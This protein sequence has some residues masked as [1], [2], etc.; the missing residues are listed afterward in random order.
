MSSCPDLS[1][2][3]KKRLKNDA[4]VA[5]KWFEAAPDVLL[6]HPAELNPRFR[7]LSPARLG[8]SRKRIANVR[9]SVR[10]VLR[11]VDTGSGWSLAKELS[12]DWR[13]LEAK[14]PD[15]YRRA[16][17]RCLVQF[18]SACGVPPDE[19]D[20]AQSAR[21]LD[22]LENSRLRGRPKVTHKNAVRV[23][24]QLA[25]MVEGW[26]RQK[27]TLPRYGDTYVLPWG[28]FPRSLVADVERFLDRGST[29]DPFDL[30]RPYRAWRPQTVATYRKLLRRFASA[31]VHAGVEAERIKTLADLCSIEKVTLGLRWC[32]DRKP[33]DSGFVAASNMAR[34]LAQIARN[35]NGKSHLTAVEQQKYENTAKEI[36]ELAHRLRQRAPEAATARLRLAPLRDEQNLA[37]LYLLPFALERE[38]LRA[39]DETR[40]SAL[41]AQW[42]VALMI[43]TFCP[44]RV[45]TLCQI[46][47]RHLTWS[48]PGMRGELSLEFPTDEL[49]NG[50]PASMPLPPECAK[51]IRL[52]VERFRPRLV[53]E[54]T[55]FLFPGANAAQSKGP[56]TMGHQLKRLIWE[57]AGLDVNCHLYRHMVHLVVLK[58]FPGAYAMVSRV[59]THKSLETAVRNYSHFDVEL[60]MRAYHALVRDV[61]TGTARQKASLN[62]IA[63]M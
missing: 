63:Y 25:D 4:R 3:S 38:V 46:S 24:N 45:S 7:R 39:K 9:N 27:L 6:A 14:I 30:S 17:L 58:R 20:D 19:F 56:G 37:R 50:E 48:R 1:E 10:N 15:A 23:W 12:A 34:L 51:L 41:V 21:L 44:L 8:V 43:E 18:G 40:K 26:P 32:L 36:A 55:E 52:Y 61:Q 53:A 31:L 13:A 33:D 60:S 57:R 59:L 35:P 2:K 28:S 62:S 11:V 49:K 16:A 47:S 5:C 29:A 22:N 42:A 54:P